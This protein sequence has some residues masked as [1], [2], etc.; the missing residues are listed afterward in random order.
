VLLAGGGEPP[1]GRLGNLMVAVGFGGKLMRTVS[2]LGCTFAASAGLGGT[3]PPGRFGLLSG[4]KFIQWLKLEL[5]CAGVKLLLS[6]GSDRSR[7][8]GRIPRAN[9][10]AG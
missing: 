9:K 6:D 5:T 7:Q 8:I 1:G 4:I 2:F 3:G 10:N